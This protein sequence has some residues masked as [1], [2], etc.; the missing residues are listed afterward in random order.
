MKSEKILRAHNFKELNV[1][2]EGRILIKE[3]YKITKEFPLDEKFGIVSQLRRAAISISSIIAEGTGRDTEN[4]LLNFL[5][6]S[7]GSSYEVES[8]LIVS[9][10][11]KYINEEVFA[12]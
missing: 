1:W 5:N 2:K 8:L 4:Q 12:D 6:F 10:D 9:L 7:K 11:L 3:I